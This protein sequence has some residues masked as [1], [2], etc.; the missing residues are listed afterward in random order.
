MSDSWKH[1]RGAPD[2]GARVCAIADVPEGGTHCLELNGFPLLLVHTDGIIRAYVNA[3]PHQYLPLNHKG[4]NLISADKT[5]LRCTNHNAGF[6]VADGEGV[7]A[8]GIGQCLDAVPVFL[9]DQSVM[10]GDG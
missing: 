10:I 3:C 4:D 2:L 8:L 9:K 6:S 1:Y 7:E 5:I